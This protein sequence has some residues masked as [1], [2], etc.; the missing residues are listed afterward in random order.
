MWAGLCVN[1]L[2]GVLG[3]GITAVLAWLGA[4]A[5]ASAFNLMLFVLLWTLPA[6]LLTSI[7]GK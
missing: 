6:L 7:A 1:L 5:A 3:F 2:G 4:F